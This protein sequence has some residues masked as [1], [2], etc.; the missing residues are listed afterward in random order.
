MALI[1]SDMYVQ[2]VYIYEVTWI[3]ISTNS[4]DG[5]N[6]N[7]NASLSNF[8]CLNRDLEKSPLLR[9]MQSIVGHMM[10]LTLNWYLVS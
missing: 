2:Y 8:K 10:C 6:A 9:D 3:Y 1:L 5:P 7:Y 4:L